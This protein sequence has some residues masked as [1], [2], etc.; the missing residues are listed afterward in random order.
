MTRVCDVSRSG[1][2]RDN[3][4]AGA[5]FMEVTRTEGEGLM[6]GSA[7]LIGDII[8]FRLNTAP[9]DMQAMFDDVVLIEGLYQLRDYCEQNKL[10]GHLM[11]GCLLAKVFCKHCTTLSNIVNYF[12]H[13]LH[14]WPKQNIK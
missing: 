11:M 6:M 13:L 2:G 1:D 7:N 5:L 14:A 9:A 3:A 4:T 8:Q 10:S 12:Q